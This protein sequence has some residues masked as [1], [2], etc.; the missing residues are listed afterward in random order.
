MLNALEIIEALRIC[1]NH[2]DMA[3]K[4]CA[5]C[6]YDKHCETESVGVPIELVAADM[7]EKLLR[8]LGQTAAEQ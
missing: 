7:I 8:Q 5:D 2:P 3:G 4:T 6:P 1:G